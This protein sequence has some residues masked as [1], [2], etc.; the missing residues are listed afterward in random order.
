[1]AHEKKE[2][3]GIVVAL[4]PTMV[5]LA[6]AAA[7]PYSSQCLEFGQLVLASEQSD[8]VALPVLEAFA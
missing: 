5:L 3:V 8:V 6:A 1:M 7:E 4:G 2:A